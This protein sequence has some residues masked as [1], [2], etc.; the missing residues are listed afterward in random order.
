MAR[1]VTPPPRRADSLRI[2]A[3]LLV[4]ARALLERGELPLQLNELARRAGVGVGT[5]YRHFASSRSLLETLALEPFHELLDIARAAVAE[6]DPWTALER[7]LYAQVRLEVEHNGVREVLAAA[8]DEQPDTAALKAE[9]DALTDGLLRRARSAGAVRDGVDA[10][11][12]RSLLCGIGYAARIAGSAPDEAA[13]RYLRV[14]ADG[15][16]RR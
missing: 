14:L 6:P 13:E 11:D 15:L 1:T 8:A 3:R 9:L 4:E 7:L 2:R 5:V 12:I 10:A 16:R